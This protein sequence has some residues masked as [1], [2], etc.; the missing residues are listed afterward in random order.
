[1]RSEKKEDG[2]EL[3]FIASAR[4]RSGPNRPVEYIQEMFSVLTSVIC[5]LGLLCL[6][7]AHCL[8]S[9]LSETSKVSSISKRAVRSEKQQEGNGLISFRAQY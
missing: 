9:Q 4:G 7:I 6:T 2:P 3:D 8:K 1:M 5:L